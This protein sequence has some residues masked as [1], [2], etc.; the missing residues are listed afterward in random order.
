MT[1]EQSIE[2]IGMSMEV[3]PNTSPGAPSSG[4]ADL[5]AIGRLEETALARYSDAEL[6]QLFDDIRR[7]DEDGYVGVAHSAA[8]K[9]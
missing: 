4:G 6:D 8:V 7:L 9:D 3:E 1:S 5:E 2:A